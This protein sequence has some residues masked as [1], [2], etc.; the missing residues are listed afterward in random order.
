MFVTIKK[1]KVST[2]IFP[3]DIASRRKIKAV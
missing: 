3:K 1:S 2:V